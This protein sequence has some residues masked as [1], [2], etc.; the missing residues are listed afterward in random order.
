MQSG[1]PDASNR[2][3]RGPAAPTGRGG[4]QQR[5]WYRGLPVPPG[6]AGNF[7]RRNNTNY[8]QTGVLSALQLTAAFPNLI[9]DNFYRKT[10]NSIESGKTD[11]PYGFVLPVQRD[12][13]RVAELVRILRIQRIELGQATSEIKVSDGTFPA[14]SYVIKRDQPYGRLAKNLLEKQSFPDPGLRTYDDSGWTMGMA[15]LTE[16]KEI[17]DK[18]ILNVKTTPVSEVSLRGKVLGAGSAGL[19]VAHFG[20]NNMIALRFQ[21]RSMPMKIAGRSFTAEGIEFPSGSFVISPPADM[22]A[23]RAA[24]EQLGLTAAALRSLPAVPMHD[25]DVPRVAMYSSWNGTQ[26]IGWVRFTFDRFGIPYDLIYK[27]RVRQGNL[28]S[29][30]DVIVMPTQQANRQVVY[31]APA[32][33]AV[34]YMKSE[35]YKFLGMYG[36][37]EDIT[38]GMGGEGV[39][40]FA[41]FLDAGGTLVA[42][43]SAVRFPTELGFARTVDASA[44][45]SS[46]FYAPRPIVNAEVLKLEHPVFYGYKDKIMPV[47]YLGGPLMSVGP[48]DQ[49][50]VLAR[51]VGGDAAVLSGLMKGADEIRQRP[52]AVDVPGG[53]TGRG[54]VVLFAN[55]PIYR[56]QNHGEFNMVFNTLLNWN[57]LAGPLSTAQKTTPTVGAQR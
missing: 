28:R 4:A 39:D 15:M 12:M 45:T 38:G 2:G 34:P 50:G 46:E 57:D 1:A 56:W 48:P 42:M 6:A 9:V 30:Y 44:S 37:S 27:E 41:K 5:E 55:N 31:Q 3:G 29:D 23:A 11:P 22:T 21:L 13:T 7:S 35:K 51:Y 36:E 17:A 18:A 33:R 47:K 8:M 10:R 25:A 14:G 19:A 20:S 49:A 24:V 32:A 52:F 26:E 53:F 40:A 54:R 16:V 43:G